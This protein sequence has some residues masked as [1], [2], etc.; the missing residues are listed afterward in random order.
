M[1]ATSNLFYYYF[2]LTIIYYLTY[3]NFVIS[4]IWVLQTSNNKGRSDMSLKIVEL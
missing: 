2:I 4:K 1:N 3:S